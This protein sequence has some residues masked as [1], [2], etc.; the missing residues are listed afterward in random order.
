MIQRIITLEHTCEGFRDGHYFVL[1]YSDGFYSLVKLVY[2]EDVYLPVDLLP[3]VPESH[4]DPYVSKI[5]ERDVSDYVK[6]RARLEGR[7]FP[8]NSLPRVSAIAIEM[9]DLLDEGKDPLLVA[10]LGNFDVAHE[11]N[12]L[13]YLRGDNDE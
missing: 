8:P 9:W 11:S 5:H 1:G 4:V 10:A 6:H 3:T 12:L 2:T 7:R 13:L